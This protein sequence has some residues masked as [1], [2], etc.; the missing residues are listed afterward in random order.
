MRDTVSQHSHHA[1]TSMNPKALQLS[2]GVFLVSGCAMIDQDLVKDGV[3]HVE[4]VPSSEMVFARVEVTR[5]GMEV[6]V[7]GSLRHVHGRT[8]ETI[9]GHVD[10]VITDSEGN[11]I[12]TGTIPYW[13]MHPQST[14]H[15]VFGMS[16]WIDDG[17][18]VKLS[19][20]ESEGEN[21]EQ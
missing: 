19:H 21:R 1:Q 9:P 14:M 7:S 3:V 6:T 20:H 8:R 2:L 15:F 17:T 12:A 16:T 13:P 10:I 5:K 11:L 4:T 18:V